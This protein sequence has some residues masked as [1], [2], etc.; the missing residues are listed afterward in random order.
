M[1]EE[2]VKQTT[3]NSAPKKVSMSQRRRLRLKCT[4]C[5]A[6]YGRLRQYLSHFETK[7]YQ[8]YQQL[9]STIPE[10]SLSLEQ[11]QTPN[12]NDGIR[13]DSVGLYGANSRLAQKLRQRHLLQGATNM[14][15]KNKLGK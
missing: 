15:Y 9:L 7:H 4:M 6:S 10:T 1:S 11:L 5:G 14:Y 2:L 13:N 12:S 3:A 8:P